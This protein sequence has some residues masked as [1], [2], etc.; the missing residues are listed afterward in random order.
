MKIIP[1]NIHEYA[2]QINI[3]TAQQKYSMSGAGLKGLYN[4][5]QMHFHWSSEHTLDRKR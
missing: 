2:V 1:V 4:M 3:D 5:V